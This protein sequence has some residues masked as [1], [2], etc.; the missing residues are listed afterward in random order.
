MNRLGQELLPRTALPT[1]ENRRWTARHLA[2]RVENSAEHLTGSHNQPEWINF[3]VGSSGSLF[4]CGNGDRGHRRADHGVI[5]QLALERQ[6]APLLLGDFLD[7]ISKLQVQELDRAMPASAL[8]SRTGNLCEAGQ[9]VQIIGPVRPRILGAQD[10]EGLELRL[11]H[12][13]IGDFASQESQLPLCSVCRLMRPGRKR[14]PLLQSFHQRAPGRQFL[15]RRG[16]WAQATRQAINGRFPVAEVNA[17]NTCDSPCGPGLVMLDVPKPG[18]TIEML[19]AMDNAALNGFNRFTINGVAFAMDKMEPMF[20][21]QYGKRYRLR[22]RNATDDVHPMHLHRHSFEIIRLAGNPT[23]GVLK[24]VVML[25]SYQ[26]MEIDFT[27]DQLGLSLFHCH[28][29]LHMDFGLM[30]LFDCR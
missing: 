5:G 29:Q 27:A 21:L 1:D 30:A 28:M 11:V 14:A 20:R 26:E 10:Q 3:W 15:Q 4:F 17:Y 12:Q 7:L 19:I 9:Q 23:A 25:G 22:L 2:R 13:R 18:E 6:N 24:D 16:S 8:Q